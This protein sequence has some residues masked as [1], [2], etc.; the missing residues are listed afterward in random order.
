[1][2]SI[3]LDPLP[4][5]ADYPLRVL[6]I[7]PLSF[8]PSAGNFKISSSCIHEWIGIIAYRLMGRL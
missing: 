8:L 4:E 6:A 7:D 3:G 5:A 2:K 1:M